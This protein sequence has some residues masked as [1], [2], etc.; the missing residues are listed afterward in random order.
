M[1]RWHLVFIFATLIALVQ[2]YTVLEAED[3]IGTGYFGLGYRWTNETVLTILGNASASFQFPHNSTCF[4][5]TAELPTE[6][7][8]TELISSSLYFHA[9]RSFYFRPFLDNKLNSGQSQYQEP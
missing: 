1:S 9:L 7:F 8:E 4:S 2:G 3:S 6:P 5:Y